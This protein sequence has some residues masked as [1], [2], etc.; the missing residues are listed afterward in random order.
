MP[1]DGNQPSETDN[2]NA[3]DQGMG[4]GEL[5]DGREGIHILA[6]VESGFTD[7]GD[8]SEKNP[9]RR[10]KIIFARPTESSATREL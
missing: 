1:D 7:R 2:R 10:P 6:V 3:E 5:K 4:C 9:S 8:G